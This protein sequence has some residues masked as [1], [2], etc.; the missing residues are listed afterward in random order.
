MKPIVAR[1]DNPAILVASTADMRQELHLGAEFAG[2][3][4]PRPPTGAFD[5][6]AYSDDGPG[7]QVPRAYKHQSV[8]VSL[9]RVEQ[10]TWT[11]ADSLSGVWSL[12]IGRRHFDLNGHGSIKIDVDI[13]EAMLYEAAVAPR[14]YALGANY[15]NPFNPQT[16]IGYSLAKSGRVTLAIYDVLGRQVRML[17]DQSQE[18][19]RYQVAWDGLDDQGRGVA[20][21]TYLYRLDA[22]SFRQTAKMSLVR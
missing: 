12:E 15:P 18:A 1:I 19:G 3:L 9:Q 4:P 13:R 20:S 5:V 16:T 10:I 21:G 17:V 22:G 11:V 6:R 8:W 7:W 2:V 14:R